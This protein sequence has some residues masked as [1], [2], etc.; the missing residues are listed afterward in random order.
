M[1]LEVHQ[2]CALDLEKEHKELFI[3]V[4]KRTAALISW[5]HTKVC[6]ETNFK[7]CLHKHWCNVIFFAG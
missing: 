6:A 5:K 3:Q 4:E 2:I 1:N 7:F